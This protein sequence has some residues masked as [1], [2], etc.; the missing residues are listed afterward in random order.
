MAG[1][2]DARRADDV[3]PEVAVLADLRLAGVQSH[4]HA[5]LR[6]ARPL[7]RAERALGFDR[8][9]GRVL[10]AREREE[11]GV[12]L[13]VDLG[14]AVAVHRAAHD[15]PVV[16]HDRAYSSPSSCSNRVEP[17]MSLN[18]KVTVPP[19]S[20]LIAR[21]N[22]LVEIRRATTDEEFEALLAVR[23]EVWP[24]DP[25]ASRSSVR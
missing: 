17:S 16:V 9:V 24:R 2:A 23:N 11:E 3:D 14:A 7:V 15:P 1:R 19:G 4:P 5:D 6:A 20:A 10:R 18:R 8:G 13:R 22:R 12:A 25:S 21:K